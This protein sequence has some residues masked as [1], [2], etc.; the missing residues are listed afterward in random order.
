MTSKEKSVIEAAKAWRKCDEI[1]PI[2]S[3]KPHELL[4]K[5]AYAVDDLPDKWCNNDLSDS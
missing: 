5:L 4:L 3:K 2:G 1:E